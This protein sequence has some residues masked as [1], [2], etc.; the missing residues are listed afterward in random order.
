MD[1]ALVGCGLWGRNILRELAFLNAHALVIDPNRD[2]RTYAEQNGATQTFSDLDSLPTVDG[3]ILSTP[4]SQHAQ[5]IESLL[6]RNT[7]IF[8]EK[9]FVLNLEDAIRLKSIG[10]GK[11]FVMHVWR[12]HP[13]VQ[14]LKE[15]ITTNQL[16]A[17]ELI[18]TRRCNWTS[19]RKDVDPIWTLL[20]HDISIITELTGAVPNPVSAIPEYCSNKPVG[21]IAH[22]EATCPCISEVSTRYPDKIREIRVHGSDGIATLLQDGNEL[23]LHWGDINT[24]QARSESVMVDG[25]PALRAEVR[26]FL[27]FLQGGE[28]P[29][30]ELDQAVEITR[31][32]TKLRSMAGLANE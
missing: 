24:E 30:T 10:A 3:F 25:E 5:Q 4:A 20:P 11:V 12:Y 13:V 31:C 14:Q 27:D 15:M 2:A 7:P 9:P 26:A 8:T 22:T 21:L 29:R 19:P 28:A 16:G 18:R 1:I 23:T 17:L 6:A 32:L